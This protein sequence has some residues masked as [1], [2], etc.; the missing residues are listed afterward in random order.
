MGR[1]VRRV[2]ADWVHPK[3]ER[4]RYIPLLNDD[5]QKDAQEFLAKAN[6][7]GLQEAVD[8]YG[9]PEKEQYMPNWP[10]EKRT[11]FMMYETCTEGTPISPAFDTPE[12][13]ARW[14]ADTGASAFAD[15][16]ASYDAWLRIARGGFAPSAVI[17][18]GRVVSGVEAGKG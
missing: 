15:T 11:H 18:G 8:Y 16:T 10:T 4:G 12:K 1:E 3:D 7:E 5:Y 9:V 6:A 14:L 13:L 2:P 17:V